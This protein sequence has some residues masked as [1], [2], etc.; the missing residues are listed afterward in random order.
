ML[1]PGLLLVMIALMLSACSKGDK[2][3][4]DKN[5]SASA[6]AQA[7]KAL[8]VTPEDLYTV[9]TSAQTSG[10]VVTGT[11]QPERKADL[12]AEIS[13][14]VLQVLKENGDPV[15]RGDLLVRLDDTAI[16][17]S[18]RSAEEAERAS[19]QSFD[20]AERQLQRYKTLRASGMAS[21]QQ[22]EDAEVRRNNAQSD[23]VA[24]K[25]RTVQARQQ[26]QRTE[27]RA[28]FDGVVSERK[29]SG[30][31]TAAIGKEMLKVIDPASMRLEGLISA[32]RVAQVKA[33]QDVTFRINGYAGQ[34]FTGKVKRV[35]TSANATTRQLAVLIGFTDGQVPGIAG[36]YA[37]GTIASSS[38]EV[39]S[40][41][42]SALVRE[43]DKAYAWQF[44]GG[45]LR[46][47]LLQLG[48]RDE[49]TGNYAI[50]SGLAAGDQVI[51]TPMSTL[52]DGQTATLVPSA[53]ANTAAAPASAAAGAASAQAAASAGK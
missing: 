44:K 33:G 17:D 22:L 26:L 27:I 6:S 19:G 29:V 34:T 52:K 16:R 23:L 10:P 30:G 5:A 32:D 18:L 28:P 1:R 43:G 15:K 20:Q 37:E 13:S 45:V 53:K 38:R 48:E 24:A 21:A 7:A 8:Q 41:E 35:D 36:L 42:S 14:V 9:K 3:A 47:A 51:R 31:D 50:V 2:A 4:E 39:L 11:I 40:L 25:A 12:R 46:K 49:R